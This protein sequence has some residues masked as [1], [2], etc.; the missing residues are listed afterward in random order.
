MPY[1]PRCSA[2][3]LV[4]VL[5]LATSAAAQARPH[6]H[7][8]RL[9]ADTYSWHAWI[10]A[11]PT[12]HPR[13]HAERHPRKYQKVSRRHAQRSVAH[14]GLV[15][16]HV[17]GHTS[18]VTA[19]AH[20]AFQGFLNDVSRLGKIQSLGCYSSGGHMPGSKHHWGGACDI[21]QVARSVTSGF[22]RHV[23]AIAHRHGLTD[24]C[25]WRHP[26]CGHIEVASRRSRTRYA[27]L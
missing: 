27:R 24:G 9:R 26:D 11:K 19:S 17:Q 4:A 22:M 5:V 7:D 15:P 20:H 1:V 2:A 12:V 10:S 23:T 25:T 6:H 18:L 21:N 14:G 13:R 8:N 16:V 3:T